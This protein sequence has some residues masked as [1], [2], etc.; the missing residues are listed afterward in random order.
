[1]SGGRGTGGYPGSGYGGDYGDDGYDQGGTPA[2][3]PR[4]DDSVW[5]RD[6][7][8]AWAAQ[9][10]DQTH[11]ASPGYDPPGYG[12]PAYD[13]QGYDQQGYT[14]GQGYTGPG[15]GG[16]DYDAPGYPGQAYP[17]AGPYRQ[18]GTPPGPEHPEQ[19][20][21]RTGP[22]PVYPGSGA[23]PLQRSTGAQSAYP[24]SGPYPA[25]PGQ[26]GPAT[27]S[28]P[29]QRGS[30]GLPQVPPG[31]DQRG[32]GTGGHRMAGPGGYD[33]PRREGPQGDDSFLPGFGPRDDFEG[34]RGQ[35]RSRN[36][37]A[38]GNGR[39]AYDDYNAQRGTAADPR[40]RDPAGYPGAADTRRQ[41]G[42][43][44][45]AHV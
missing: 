8:D 27:G 18:P 28:R 31:Y 15:Y 37:Q 30:G 39:G 44:G 33:D 32:T 19:H 40:R 4:W 36:G 24:G 29:V 22:Q 1:M 43:I 45:R 35:G 13:Q 41:P 25:Q 17:D 38:S 26:R 14:G 21:P 5:Q 9:D 2:G 6:Q 20:Y 3:E 34:G 16:Q 7:P 11:G 10:P 12:R 42:Q 23:Q